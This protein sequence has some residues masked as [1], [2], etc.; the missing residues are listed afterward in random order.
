MTSTYKNHKT[1][2]DFGYTFNDKGE[3]KDIKTDK[4]FS[5]VDQEHYEALGE[6]ITD[7]VYKL[8]QERAGLEIKYLNNDKNSFVF[9]SPE[10]LGEV[11]T[12]EVYKLLQERAGL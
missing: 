2:A 8:L 12:D 4:P 7:E 10:A 6:V 5:F 1:L 11:I 9:V 3:L